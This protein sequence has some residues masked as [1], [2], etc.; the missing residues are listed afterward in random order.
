[1]ARPGEEVPHFAGPDWEELDPVNVVDLGGGTV[2]LN[3][4]EG[5]EYRPREHGS[6]IVGEVDLRDLAAERSRRTDIGGLE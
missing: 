2:T 4:F 5:P 6:P 1:M 3:A